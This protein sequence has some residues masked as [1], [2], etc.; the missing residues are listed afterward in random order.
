MTKD[1]SHPTHNMNLISLPL[2]VPCFHARIHARF[3]RCFLLCF[4]IPLRILWE[5]YC[6]FL[7]FPVAMSVRKDVSLLSHNIN[8]ISLP[9]CVVFS[10][11]S[12]R[13]FSSA[14]FVVSGYQLWVSKSFV[15]FSVWVSC[16]LSQ[17][18]ASVDRCYLL[19]FLIPLRGLQQLHCYI[20]AFRGATSL[21]K[22]VC[23]VAH[24]MNIIISL[25]FAWC[26][27]DQIHA[28]FVSCYHPCFW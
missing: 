21:I 9:V 3:L 5:P 8:I 6:Y 13:V 14:T 27:L 22:E 10:R 15:V 16:L 1:V 25:L 18:H 2:L 4:W 20:S 19:W 28:R 17:F 23:H 12:T 26:F 24:N 7:Q 11:E